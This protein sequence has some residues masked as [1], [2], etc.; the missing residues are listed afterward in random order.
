MKLEPKPIRNKNVSFAELDL[1][2]FD[3]MMLCSHDGGQDQASRTPS[4]KE[5]SSWRH[6]KTQKGNVV[7]IKRIGITCSSGSKD[8]FRDRRLSVET[9]LG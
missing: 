4:L 8:I 2:G 6:K 7:P 9:K 5:L 1:S 3:S